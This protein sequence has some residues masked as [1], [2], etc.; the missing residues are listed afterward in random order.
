[1]AN[2]KKN[3]FGK[4]EMFLIVSLPKND[5]ELA[6]AAVDGGAHAL[7]V[8]L[9]VHHAASGTHFGTLAEER[10]NIAKIISI[11]DKA[12]AAAGIM[13]GAEQTAS[14]DEL[15]ELAAMGI[16]FYDIY[17]FHMPAEYFS[18]EKIEPMVAL[19]P[20]FAPDS[21]GALWRMGVKFIEASCV[22]HE[23]YG[24]PLLMSDLEMYE[25]ICSRFGGKV[26][27]PTQKA[28][29]PSEAGALRAAG[30]RG[31]MIGAIVAGREPETIQRATKKF[32][33]AIDKL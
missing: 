14:V 21:A 4:S 29:K 24:K 30:V 28:I 16:R 11:A 15:C 6:R 1:M 5:P 33:K 3:L 32:R 10:E 19:G 26:V 27:V 8:H 31:L 20:G 25:S 22:A 7:K 9:N 23:D 13:P 12:D 18:V 2:K 17:D